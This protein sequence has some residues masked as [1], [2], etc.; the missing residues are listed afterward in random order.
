MA[1]FLYVYE[2]EI[3]IK[4]NEKCPHL[5]WILK[6]VSPLHMLLRAEIIFQALESN[7]CTN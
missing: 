4:E 3:E 6:I 5:P 1:A 2:T 7:V